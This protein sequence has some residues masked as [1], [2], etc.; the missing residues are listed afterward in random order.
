LLSLANSQPL[1]TNATTTSSWDG[2]SRTAYT[3]RALTYNGASYYP[4]YTAS[5]LA[6]IATDSNSWSKNFILMADIDLASKNWTSIALVSD[7]T[8]TDGDNKSIYSGIFDGNGH[9]I[10]NL[11]MSGSFDNSGSLSV[12]RANVGFFGCSK[13]TIKNFSINSASMK[14]SGNI[15]GLRVAPVVG[16]NRGAITNVSVLG[17]SANYNATYKTG[18]YATASVCGASFGGFVGL[19]EGTISDC[20]AVSGSVYATSANHWTLVGYLPYSSDV[21][22][23]ALIGYNN[24]G[25]YSNNTY[26]GISVSKGHATSDGKNGVLSSLATAISQINANHTTRLAAYSVGGL[27]SS[28]YTPFTSE[29]VAEPNATSTATETNAAFLALKTCDPANAYSEAKAFKDKY[30][31][32]VDLQ[33]VAN[34]TTTDKDDNGN[35]VTAYTSVDKMNYMLTRYANSASQ[36]NVLSLSTASTSQSTV[37]FLVVLGVAALVNASAYIYH[38]QKAK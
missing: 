18:S 33:N 6:Y 9:T 25:T 5:E 37:T 28:N 34:A 8:T 11:S 12:R 17:V 19:N 1:E 31:S 7:S 36:A 30:D 4:I 23:G 27:Y 38:R 21:H 29:G 24:G 16:Y 20:L 2:S 26:S 22:V 10:S 14:V 32:D 13:G 15:G 35:T 3:S